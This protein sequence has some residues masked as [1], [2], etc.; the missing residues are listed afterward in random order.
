MVERPL[1]MRSLSMITSF[2]LSFC[3][4]CLQFFFPH[5]SAH[6]T[7]VV[8]HNFLRQNYCITHHRYWLLFGF[9]NFFLINS[10]L[11]ICFSSYNFKTCIEVFCRK[12]WTH[13]TFNVKQI[14]IENI[15]IE[16]DYYLLKFLRW[17]AGSLVAELK[18]GF[19][20]T[21]CHGVC[22]SALKSTV[23]KNGGCTFYHTE[24]MA[25][26]DYQSR[27]KL[28]SLQ[29]LSLYYIHCVR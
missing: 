9:S 27:H 5:L 11:D 25:Y 2:F 10:S 20:D 6:K 8:R 3:L 28:I 4:F 29:H 15:F 1:R 17:A 16:C 7:Q 14:F 26:L 12:P 13:H 24:C 22:N 21:R 18:C 19:L 23:G